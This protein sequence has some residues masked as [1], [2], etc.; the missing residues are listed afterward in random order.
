MSSEKPQITFGS[1]D[2][3]GFDDE[4]LERESERNRVPFSTSLDAGLYEKLKAMHFYDNIGIADVVNEAVRR[5]IAEV[6]SERGE[7]YDVPGPL[8][9]DD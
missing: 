4:Q 5:A 9:I 7:P 8:R 1:E 6:E 2:D 3:A